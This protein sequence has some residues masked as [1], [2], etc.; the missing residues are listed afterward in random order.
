MRDW[1]FHKNDMNTAQKLGFEENAKLLIIHA[2]DAG[3]SHSENR[4][5]IQAMQFGIVNSYSIMVPCPWFYEMAGFAKKNPQFDYGIHLTLTCEWENYKFGPVL[6]ASEVPSLVDENGHFFKKREQLR[7]IA[8]PEDVAKELRAQMEKAINNGLTPSH[9]DSHMYSVGAHPKF[10]EVYKN[11]GEQ[12][13]LPV[14]INEQLMHMVGLDPKSNL[15]E[16]DFV[17]DRTYVGEY[18]YFEKEGLAA[19][20]QSILE[21]LDS[22][23]NLILIHPAFD[24]DEMK[25]V[26]INHPNFGSEWRHQDFE[27]FTSDKTEALLK[28]HNI[29]LV[30]WNDIK[31]LKK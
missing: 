20:Y 17:I 12:F 2:D 16:G 21:N 10:F 26:T 19:Y 24:D 4:A 30:T 28:E 9:I 14:L 23:L 1:L 31:N 15:E 11:L 22:G 18:P 27:F 5:T 13:N 25:G 3:L 8:S 29:Q 6:P 7:E